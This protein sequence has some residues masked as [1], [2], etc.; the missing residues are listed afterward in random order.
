MT[1]L[2]A[3]KDESCTPVAEFC[4][5]DLQ[6]Q[7]VVVANLIEDTHVMR[8]ILRDVAS[9]S[10][11]H[12]VLLSRHACDRAGKK[13]LDVANSMDNLG[14]VSHVTV[15]PL[16]GRASASNCLAKFDLIGA[17]ESYDPTP[18]WR[19]LQVDVPDRSYAGATAIRLARQLQMNVIVPGMHRTVVIGETSGGPGARRTVWGLEMS[20]AE[21][22]RAGFIVIGADGTAKPRIVYADADDRMRNITR[23]SAA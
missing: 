4:N 20:S 17:D 6:D 7:S 12:L 9:Y 15:L 1:T 16:A 3:F 18:A 14:S 8:R 10:P 11:G 23:R 19:I 22:K 5:S 2:A 21:G 13:C